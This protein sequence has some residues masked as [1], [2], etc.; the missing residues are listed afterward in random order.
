MTK[1]LVL[2]WFL[3]EALRP[4]LVSN[5]GYH[6]KMPGQDSFF[7]GPAALPRSSGI[8]HTSSTL[9]PHTIASKPTVFLVCD[10][11]SDF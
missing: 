9:D 10:S 3:R 7:E 8:R 6:S 11:Q 4:I 2:S 5:N 1:N